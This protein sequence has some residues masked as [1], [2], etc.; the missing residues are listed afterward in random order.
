MSFRKFSLAVI[1]MAV[2][3]CGCGIK[4][5]IVKRPMDTPVIMVSPLNSRISNEQIRQIIVGACSK[6]GW[7][8]NNAT[9]SNV[10][11]TLNHQG[12][13]TVTV[14]IPYSRDKVEIRYK[15]S[16]NMRFDGNKIHRS[17]N[18]WVKNLEVDIRNGIAS[19]R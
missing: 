2:F 11:A 13:E 14:D 19:A 16:T 12:K 15:S 9:S 7:A 10:E 5:S 6:H 1:V 17:Y 4:N 3:L 18:R 8:V